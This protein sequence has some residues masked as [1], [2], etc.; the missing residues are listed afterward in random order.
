MPAK[1]T[2]EYQVKRTGDWW[3]ASTP[4]VDRQNDRVMP[5]GLDLS[6]YRRNPVVMWAHDYRSPFAVVGRAEDL[7]LTATDFRIKPQWRKPVNDQ[8]PMNI[9]QALIDEGLV[10]A[11]SIGFRPLEETPNDYGGY[12]FTRA[13]ILEVSVVPIPANQQAL[14]LAAKALGPGTTKGA[15]K[16]DVV[17]QAAVLGRKMD[18]YAAG[19]SP[20][21]AK[22][23]RAAM[24][25]L[26]LAILGWKLEEFVA[27]LQRERRRG[28]GS[29]W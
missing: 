27:R 18:R 24:I 5:L 3:I 9:I 12:D 4:V 25:D 1:I 10:R 16:A 20:T 23:L 21:E 29:G 6:N 19:L 11:M 15:P 26:R 8:D 14:A 28:T 7:Q 2:K 13:E 22:K 17:T